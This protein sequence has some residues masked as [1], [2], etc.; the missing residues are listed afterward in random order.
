MFSVGKTAQITAEMT[1]YGTGILRI[2]ECRWS[3]FGRLKARAGETI[4]SSCRDDDVHQS[5]VTI[6]TSTKV[7]QCLDSWRPICDRI[8]EARFFS[9]FIETTAIQVY[10]PTNEADNELKDD[11]Y[12]QLQK[13][14]DEVPRRDM[15]LVIGDWNAKVGEQQLGRGRHCRKVRYD[16]G[17]K[18]QRGAL[19]VFLR[20]KQSCY[21]IDYVPTKRNTQIHVDFAKWPIPQPDRSCGR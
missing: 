4:I 17:K 13:I 16:R 14:V 2:S 10:A 3:G 12:E 11:L 20:T 9:R 1:R 5:G 21:C 15:L 6:I 7:A 19:C 18:R 8:I